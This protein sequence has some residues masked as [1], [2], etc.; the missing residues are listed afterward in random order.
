[1]EIFGQNR[2]NKSHE[3]VNQQSTNKMGKNVNGI[4][5]NTEMK[6][7]SDQNR[8]NPRKAELVRSVKI[9]HI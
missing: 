3:G 5:Q 9:K 2:I 7:N 1:M 6:C 8:K 4:K